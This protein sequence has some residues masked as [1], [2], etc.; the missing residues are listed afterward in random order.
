MKRCLGGKGRYTDAYLLVLP[1]QQP[2]AK[3][4]LSLRVT[5]AQ[6]PARG[7]GVRLLE[8]NADIGLLLLLVGGGAVGGGGGVVGLRVVEAEQAGVAQRRQLAQAP[9][10][11]NEGGGGGGGY[12][13]MFRR[14]LVVLSVVVWGRRVE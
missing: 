13:G 3:P 1:R 7:G 5:L 12:G 6:H 10:F 9:G 11:G 8:H 14:I 2:P 4:A